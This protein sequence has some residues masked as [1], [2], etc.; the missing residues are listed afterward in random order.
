VGT[1]RK[2][3]DIEAWKK[4]RELTNILYSITRKN[5]HWDINLKS[6]IIRASISIM[7][8]ISEGFARKSK[9]EFSRF[10]MISHGSVAEVQ[11]ALY[12]ALDQ[13][14]INESEFKDIYDKAEEVSR[15]LMGLYNYLKK[16]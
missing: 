5:V 10:L 2:F 11:S 14:Y 9:N 4:A 16:K 1:I 15:M 8:N 6:Q 12:I 7:L 3:E 13:K